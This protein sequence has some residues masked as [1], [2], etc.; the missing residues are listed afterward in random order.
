MSGCIGCN[1]ELSWELQ[2]DG[3]LFLSLWR[4]GVET[5]RSTSLAQLGLPEGISAVT[6]QEKLQPHFKSLTAQ[7]DKSDRA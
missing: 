2:P 4:D 3:Q 6:L 7:R 1:D 5:R